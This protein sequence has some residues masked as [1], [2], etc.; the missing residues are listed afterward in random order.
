MADVDIDPFSEHGKTDEHLDEGE[1][2]P[3]TPGEA[4][5]GGSTWRPNKKC[6]LE[7]RVLVRKSSENLL[8]GCTESYPKAWAKPQK[9]SIS[10]ILN[11]EMGNCTTKARNYGECSMENL[12]KQLEG[13][14]SEMLPTYELQGLDKQLKSKKG[15][16][17]SV[18]LRVH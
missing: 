12:I 3:L 1:T 10:M 5:G 8:K 4:I 2:I 17:I 9:H 7:E 11:S 13:T 18:Y 16:K 14:S 6:H 15:K